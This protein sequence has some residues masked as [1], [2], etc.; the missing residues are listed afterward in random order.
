MV[1]HRQELTVAEVRR[2]IRAFRDRA[3]DL[4][5]AEWQMFGDG[6]NQLANFCRTDAVFSAIHEQ[7]ANNPNVDAQKWLNENRRVRLSGL[8]FPLNADDRLSLQYQIVISGA[9][10][11][12]GLM[13]QAMMWFHRQGGQMSDYLRAF[14]DSI[15]R[16]LFRD[17]GYRLEDIEERLPEDRTTLVSTASLQIIHVK[18]A[19]VHVGK[20]ETFEFHD[21]KNVQVGN[22]NRQDNRE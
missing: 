2:S 13:K 22:F 21:S 19:E 10:H 8:R 16:P 6:L 12:P 1:S 7:L 14:A 4:L 11:P 5:R 18:S 15:M 17:L 3:D 9:D 20:H